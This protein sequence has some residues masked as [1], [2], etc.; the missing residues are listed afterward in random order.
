MFQRQLRRFIS[1]TSFFCLFVGATFSLATDV[2]LDDVINGHLDS[3]A[4][5]D[6]RAGTKSRLVE[7]TAVFR[8]L[9]GGAGT[10]EGPATIASIE[11]NSLLQMKFST[12][13]RGERVVTDGN[14]VSVAYATPDQT[15]SAFGEFVYVQNAVMREGLLGGVL[16][17]AW[18]LLD[19]KERNPKLS[20]GG[21][22]N[23]DGQALYEVRYKP[24]KSADVDIRLYFD[25]ETF[26]HVLTVYSLV[27]EPRIVMGGDTMQ[28]SQNLIRYRVEEKFSDFKT[29][30]GFSL[31]HHYTIHFS[32]ET[33][34]GPSTLLDFDITVTKIVENMDLSPKNFEIK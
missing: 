33:Q 13:Y 26:R 32:Q 34:Q 18:P 22:K 4:K 27:I 11:R 30:D 1:L 21:T 29:A 28:A 8:V 19:L 10:T 6:V 9:T 24:K 2:K 5:P 20:L 25:T 7:G 16:T 14:K 15:R 23:I 12:S 3:I 31:P 17:T